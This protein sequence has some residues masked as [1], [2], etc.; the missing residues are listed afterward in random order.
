MRNLDGG[1]GY[2]GGVGVGMFLHAE[3]ESVCVG[4]T[5]HECVTRNAPA[6]LVAPYATSVPVTGV[7][8]A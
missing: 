1:R 4:G 2:E 3:L 7:A 6:R 5:G 8:R